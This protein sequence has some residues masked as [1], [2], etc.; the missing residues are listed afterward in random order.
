MIHIGEAIRKQ[1]EDQGRTSVRLARELGCHRTNLYKI[2]DKMSLDTSVL[3]RISRIL[4]YDFFQL[5]SKEL[6]Q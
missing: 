5:Y 6:E 4:K 1:V 3:L 2:Y